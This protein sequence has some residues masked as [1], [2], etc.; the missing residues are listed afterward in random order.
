MA[1]TLSPRSDPHE[2]P[3]GNFTVFAVGRLLADRT[4]RTLHVP[5]LQT[6]TLTQGA[7]RRETDCLTA[8]GRSRSTFPGW[9]YE[10]DEHAWPP[11]RVS[12][13]SIW[14]N[15]PVAARPHDRQSEDDRLAHVAMTARMPPYPVQARSFGPGL[16]GG[17][18]TGRGEEGPGEQVAR[19]APGDRLTLLLDHA[20]DPPAEVC[21]GWAI[22]T[23]PPDPPLTGGRSRATRAR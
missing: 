19:G 14:K 6:F 15:S 5:L 1:T 21:G 10:R 12:A 22:H 9:I 4:H 7:Q 8:N 3:R 17:A 23:M 18:K 20:L 2:M 16:N 11:G 13:P